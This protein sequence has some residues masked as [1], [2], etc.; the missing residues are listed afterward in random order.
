V[1]LAE[2]TGGAEEPISRLPHSRTTTDATRARLVASPQKFQS[3]SSGPHNRIQNW[4]SGFMHSDVPN[5]LRPFFTSARTLRSAQEGA[6]ERERAKSAEKAQHDRSPGTEPGS[7][8]LVSPELFFATAA[9]AGSSS[10]HRG[11]THDRIPVVKRVYCLVCMVSNVWIAKHGLSLYQSGGGQQS[12]IVGCLLGP[13]RKNMNGYLRA[14]SSIAKA[15][16]A[17]TAAVAVAS[18]AT[19]P[20]WA[21]LAARIE[22]VG[23]RFACGGHD[24]KKEGARGCPPWYRNARLVPSLALL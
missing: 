5:S 17:E 3:K 16:H 14:L 15:K 18:V 12:P 8:R 4:L 9:S 6:K 21:C 13:V 23:D 20:G 2:L 7:L 22:L 19:P 10:I 1:L 24:G 11:L